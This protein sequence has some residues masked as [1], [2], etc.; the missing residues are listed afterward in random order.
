MIE[1]F[2]LPID[3]TL[4]T[5]GQSGAGKHLLLQVTIVDEK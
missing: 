3:R 2:F 4:K 1:Q 5:S